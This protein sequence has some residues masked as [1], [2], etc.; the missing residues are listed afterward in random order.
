METYHWFFDE[1]GNLGNGNRYFVIASIL[2]KN[3]K[4]LHN[5]M[6]KTLK[7]IKS[8]YDDLQWN[9]V[10]LKANRSNKEIKEIICNS[11]VSKDIV[12]SYI[13]IDKWHLDEC[14]KK[15]KNMAYNYF[16]KILLDRFH[17]VFMN[18][19]VYIKL[20]NRSI[21]VQSINSFKDYIGIH[22]NMEL[23]LNCKLDVKYL[24]SNSKEAYNIQAADFIANAIYSKYEYN[25][26]YY[27]DLIK[28]KIKEEQLFPFKY[29][30]QPSKILLETAID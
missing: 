12:I 15:D 1:S 3:P 24:E 22:I 2:T 4:S 29:F 23:K 9:G 20:D 25:N 27:Y 18:N 17:N 11:I 7:Y 21:K 28:Y 5:K 6:K 8:N 30:G 19:S 10:E 13:V 16:L 14:F 26:C